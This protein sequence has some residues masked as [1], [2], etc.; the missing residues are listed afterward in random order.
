M[1]ESV[2]PSLKSGFLG[3]KATAPGCPALVLIMS[4][5]FSVVRV[6]IFPGSR[7]ESEQTPVSLPSLL[8]V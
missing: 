5:L 7:S 4:L 3:E 6:I 1:G 8:S 2:F